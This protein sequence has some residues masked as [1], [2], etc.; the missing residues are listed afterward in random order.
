V[1]SNPEIIQTDAAINP[2][3]SGG[4]LLDSHGRVIGVN[5]A[6]QSTNSGMMGQPSNSGV[7]FA[8]PVNTVKRVSQALIANGN[9]SY[10]Y[11]GLTAGNAP[12]SE[13]ADELKLNVKEGVLVVDVAPNGPADKAGIRGGNADETIDVHGA[14]IPTGGDIITAFNG[15]PVKQFSDLLSK[16]ATAKPGETVTLTIIRDGHQQDVKVQL[17]ERPSN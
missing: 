17:G 9:V 10:A 13:I 14:S 11:L 2:G 7:G 6:I 4:P 5:T 16:L 12:L 15:A 8:V 1:F 3:N